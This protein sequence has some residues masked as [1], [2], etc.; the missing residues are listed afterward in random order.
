[1]KKAKKHIGIVLKKLRLQKGS[2][3]SEVAYILGIK[4]KYYKAIE[5]GRG[6]LLLSQAIKLTEY[7]CVSLDI[8]C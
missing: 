7:Y 6:S 4:A 3:P 5:M 8:F 1:M 2:E